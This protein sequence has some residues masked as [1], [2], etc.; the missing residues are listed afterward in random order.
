MTSSNNLS[1]VRDT[2]NNIRVA[3]SLKPFK[4]V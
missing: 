4:Y 2:Y 1:E 3:I